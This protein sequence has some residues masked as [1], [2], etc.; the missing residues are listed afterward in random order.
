[1]IVRVGNQICRWDLTKGQ[2]GMFEGSS[3]IMA[4]PLLPSKKNPKVRRHQNPNKEIE[5]LF[6]RLPK[7]ESKETDEEPK[8][9]KR[10]M[11]NLRHMNSKSSEWFMVPV[12]NMVEVAVDKGKRKMLPEFDMSVID[13]EKGFKQAPS[14]Y[15]NPESTPSGESFSCEWCGHEIKNA[16]W[17]YNPSKKWV[18]CVGSE[19]ITAFSEE[20]K[21]GEQLVKEHINKFNRDFFEQFIPTADKIRAKYRIEKEDSRGRTYSDWKDVEAGNLVVAIVRMFDKFKDKFTGKIDRDMI[22]NA[23][24]Q[25]IGNWLKDNSKK[26]LSSPVE[27]KRRISKFLNKEDAQK[28]I[29]AFDA[30]E[31][32]ENSKQEKK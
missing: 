9:A 6:T 11:L 31:Q 13:P 17:V 22:K 15:K 1:M 25:K 10:I 16:Y 4:L 23:S 28:F 2:L 5:N 3:D 24:D 18:M 7:A 30:F 8:Y 20:G 19:C 32:R 12:K 27:L 21:T 26:L 29:T 14:L